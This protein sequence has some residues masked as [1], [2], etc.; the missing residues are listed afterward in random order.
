MADVFSK[1]VRDIISQIPFGRVTTYGIVAERAG[2]RTGARQVARIL[3]SS[4]LKYNLPWHRVINK[5]GKISLPVGRGHHAQRR[6][7]ETEGVVFKQNNSV[8][9]E[10]FLW[11]A[12][13]IF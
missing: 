9:L 1:R 8:D 4:S 6:L 11:L 5:Q 13:D 7:L 2:N 10:T 3:H 12:H